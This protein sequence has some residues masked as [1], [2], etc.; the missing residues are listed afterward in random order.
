MHTTPFYCSWKILNEAE[1]ASRG[2][3]L[4]PL[5]P[6]TEVVPSF[7]LV[8]PAKPETLQFAQSPGPS[9]QLIESRR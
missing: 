4:N 2:L 8:W 9:S 5:A 6:S 1:T 3:L 7:D